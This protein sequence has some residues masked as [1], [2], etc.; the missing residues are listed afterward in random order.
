[1]Q[2]RLVAGLA[3]QL[4]A[5]AAER[6]DAAGVGW[7]WLWFWFWFIVGVLVFFVRGQMVLGDGRGR[8]VAV[9]D[10]LVEFFVA[11]NFVAINCK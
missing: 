4:A 7:F 10:G 8:F 3:E 6:A 1:V 9:G 2:T 11:I 5:L